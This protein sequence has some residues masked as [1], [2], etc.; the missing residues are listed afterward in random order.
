MEGKLELI[1]GVRNGTKDL[2][3]KCDTMACI[4]NQHSTKLFNSI[5]KLVNHCYNKKFI[6]YS[7]LTKAK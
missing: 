1:V 6:T 5:P 7:G 2:I 3:A 4:D